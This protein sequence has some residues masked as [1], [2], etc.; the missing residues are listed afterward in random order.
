MGHEE[1]RPRSHKGQEPKPLAVPSI[2]SGD[3]LGGGGAAGAGPPAAPPQPLTFTPGMPGVPSLP[4]MPGRPYKKGTGGFGLTPPKGQERRGRSPA[5]PRAPSEPG[6][7]YTRWPRGDKGGT[8][9]GCSWLGALPKVL[10]FSPLGPMSPWGPLIP[11]PP[12]SGRERGGDFC[13]ALSA[14]DGADGHGDGGGAQRAPLRT[15]EWCQ[16]GETGPF[17]LPVGYLPALPSRPAPLEVLWGLPCPTGG[18]NRAERG[19][20]VPPTHPHPG[21]SE[22]ALTGRPAAPM[23]PTIPL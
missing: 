16:A 19:G 1:P 11:R 4:S 6:C 23:V 17:G 21:Q 20:T 7:E 9:R 5:A 22:G 2:S 18:D 15:R 10:T 12:Y 8:P 3:I 13:S 14:G